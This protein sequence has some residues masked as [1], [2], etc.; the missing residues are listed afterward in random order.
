MA[1][2]ELTKTLHTHLGDAARGV[3]ELIDAIE[4]AWVG[5]G[6]PIADA[7]SEGLRNRL[8][9]ILESI[10]AARALL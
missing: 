2:T 8:R 10:I 6:G 3:T 4:S 7:D 9:E 1:T 5:D